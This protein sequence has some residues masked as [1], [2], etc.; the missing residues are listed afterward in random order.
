MQLWALPALLRCGCL[1]GMGWVEGS[2]QVFLRVVPGFRVW[3]SATGRG[4]SKLTGSISHG[5][6]D[7]RNSLDTPGTV[8]EMC[9]WLVD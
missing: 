4:Q 5:E 1:W 6:T 2:F 7:I 3:G 8:L 9:D